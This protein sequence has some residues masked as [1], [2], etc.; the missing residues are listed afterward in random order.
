MAQRKT[1]WTWINADQ[2]EFGVFLLTLSRLPLHRSV[3][4]LVD[5]ETVSGKEDLVDNKLSFR[6]LFAHE[7]TVPFLIALFQLA[8]QMTFH[9][10]YGYFRD[11]LYY[12]ACSN[13][14]AFGYV[15]QSPLSIAI[16]AVSRWILGDSLHALRFLPALAGAGVVILAASIT[17]RI[18]GGRFAQGLAALSVV[19]AHVLIGSG[20]YFSMNAFDV[21]FWALAG[22]IVVKILTED[23]PR[24][25]IAFG[26]VVGF[27]LLNKYSVGFLCIGLVAGLLLTSHRK[28]LATK[29]FWLGAMFAF[30][31][32]LPHVMWEVRHGLPTL[33]FM[34]N[35]SQQKN[36]PVTITEFAVGQLRENNYFGAPIWLLG[37]Y[38]F[39]FHRDG[40]RCRPLGWMYVVVF[41]TMVIGNAK[42]YYLSPIYPM[43]LAGGAVFAERLIQ[44]HS[45]NWIRPVYVSLM[46][47]WSAV[48]L[49]FALPVLPVQ[50]F[51]EYEKFL[52]VTPRAEERSSL[53][54]LPQYY[55]DMF[56]WEEMVAA[57]AKVYQT[58][59][60]AEQA[61]CL[62]F[63][64]NYGE[65]GAIDFFG[66]KYGLP[67]AACAHNNYWLWDPGD[68]TGDVAI[69]LGSSRVLQKNLDDLQRR[70]RQVELVA[71]TN[72]SLCMPYENGRQFFL[73]RGMNTTF[74]RVWPEE[75]FYI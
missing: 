11:E 63:V 12:I 54:A 31:L 64:R 60:P 7:M 62:I 72:C 56:G 30:L 27:G 26:V 32:F 50:K 68:R 4:K 49:P 53:G 15:D 10:N 69:I 55:A 58:L 9:G 48:V 2:R 42:V 43:L 46:I 47:V 40:K 23:R 22:Y 34:R 70:Y 37:L 20:R 38:Y 14:L 17:R 35:A 74:Q 3:I 75:R 25:W 8:L 16:L 45:W 66:K 13:H 57:V 39:F 5:R 6:K 19:A 65:A 44:E 71:T 73:C 18:G 52:G 41:V 61:K 28:Q 67:P 36:A 24:L 51:I 33:E 1:F 21:L 29:Y 59:T